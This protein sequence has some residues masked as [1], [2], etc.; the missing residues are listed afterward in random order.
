M[1]ALKLPVL[2]ENASLETKLQTIGESIQHRQKVVEQLLLSI[3]AL[4]SQRNDLM[5]INCIPPE[6]LANIFSFVQSTEKD[7]VRRC[8]QTTLELV[9]VTHVC[10]QWRHI[11]NSCP[12]LWVSLPVK[13][14]KWT[15]EVLKR[16]REL[17]LE[18]DA[19]SL[20]PGFILSL[21]YIHRIRAL[22][23]WNFHPSEWPILKNILPE[24][25]PQLEEFCLIVRPSFPLPYIPDGVLCSTPRLHRLTLGS[26]GINWNAHKLLQSSLTHLK[27]MN[28]SGSM[29]TG[30]E[31]MALLKRMPELQVLDLENSLP[32]QGGRATNSWG[33]E[34]T[35]LLCLRTL[36]I[37]SEL[38]Q[39]EFFLR[40]LAF[41]LTAVV[42]ITLRD[43]RSNP[44]FSNAIAEVA[45][46]YSNATDTEEF[47]Q[48][49]TLG[50]YTSKYQYPI[51]IELKLLLEG[52]PNFDSFEQ[53][54][55]IIGHLNLTFHY[56]DSSTFPK[57][58]GDIFSQPF[59]EG[60]S[61]VGLLALCQHSKEIQACLP[62]ALA[63]TLGKLPWLDSVI[64]SSSST[65]D[66]LDA[67]V[68]LDPRNENTEFENSHRRPEYFA[69]LS[70]IC[71]SD[72]TF[73]SIK[74]GSP[75]DDNVNTSH[76]LFL[77]LARRC[78]L[79]PAIDTL[80]LRNCRGV[81]K[82]YI[83]FLQEIVV[84]IDVDDITQTSAD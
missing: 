43:E 10:R 65:L 9:A 22:S 5:P 24:S 7:P 70:S 38:I 3:S 45:R 52:L 39:A 28:A 61:Q 48:S 17:C 19:N 82:E 34:I 78:E 27:L 18:V 64:V 12:C 69:S 79:G 16:S 75:I 42:N 73:V 41:P 1:D 66:F 40:C 8:M 80:I 26:C 67:L 30:E 77:Y 54:S 60:I 2:D 15:E 59:A 71:L 32:N 83:K 25:A 21:S 29:P 62:E 35:H 81:S 72:M 84:N 4:Q 47:F 76:D 63:V 53:A 13:N 23:L 57:L 11:I 68:Y 58:M 33:S 49:L 50:Q 44:D 14:Q 74:A 55:D 20:G 36:R 31:F 51:R 56:F 37:D 46:N 6:I